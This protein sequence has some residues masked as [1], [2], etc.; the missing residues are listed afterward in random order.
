[1]ALAAGLVLFPVEAGAQAQAGGGRYDLSVRES[2]VGA[3]LEEL[4]A[5]TG[6][7]LVYS[8]E[9]VAGRSTVCRRD[10]ATPEE[11]LRCVVEGAE[12]DFYRLSSGTYVVIEG[13]EALPSYGSLSGEIVDALTGAPVPRARVALADGSLLARANRGGMFVLGRLLPGP[14]TL[15]VSRPGYAPARLAVTIPADGAVRRRVRLDPSVLPLDPIVVEGIQGIGGGTAAEERWSGGG[16]EGAVPVD[17]DVGLQLRRGMGVARRPLF[18]HV[19]IQGSAPGEH[20]VRL[21]GVP[22]FDPV[23]LGRTRSAFSPL[24]LRRITVRKA[25]FGVEQGSFSGGVV[26]VEHAL[27]DRA[28]RGGGTILVDPYSASAGLSLPVRALGG[29]GSLLVSGR[30][31]LWGV[32][33]EGALDEALRRWNEVDP[34]LM[35]RLVGDGGRFTD[36]LDFAPHRHG[37]DLG[38]DDLHAGLRLAFPGFRTLEASFYRGTNRVSTELFAAG[39]DDA[40]GTLDRLLLT[41]DRYGW[42]NL[43]G[44][45]EGHVLV[46]DRASVRVRGWASRHELG[47]VYGMVEGS[48][49]GYQGGTSEVAETEEAL[50]SLLAREAPAEDGNRVEEW[51]LEASADLAAGAGHFLSGGVEAVRVQSG[52]HLLNGFVRPLVSRSDVWRLSGFLKDRWRVTSGL[53][54]EGGFRA[55]SLNGGSTFAEPRAALRLDGDHGALGPWSLRLSGGIYRQFLNTVELTNVG[56]S[57]LVPHVRLWIPADP[58]LDPPR[59]RHLAAE[60]GVE[61]VEGWTLRA[62]AYHKWLD[63]IVALDYGVLLATHGG[64]PEALSQ[65]EFL[66]EAEGVAW[67][68][69]LRAGWERGRARLE[70]GYEWS[71][72][73]RTYPSRFGGERQPAPWNEPHAVSLQARIPVGAGL[74]LETDARSVWG[75]TWGLRRAYFDFLTLHGTEGGP[76]IGLPGEWDLPVLHQID[77]GL[78][79]LG[80]PGGSLVEVQGE[81]RNALGGDQVLDYSLRRG[82]APDGSTHYERVERLLPG[83]ALA[84]TVRVAF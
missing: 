20:V 81:L 47:H 56:P 44:R 38:F 57:A 30:S 70:G 34:V 3:V 59:S 54:L 52:T 72:S 78:S 84:L 66:G 21:D 26:D 36:A 19:S 12:L 39:S 77:V 15:H 49:V 16:V 61:P 67:G 28:G 41:R 1:V 8:S 69:G 5:L 29:E 37:S 74:S 7:S 35:R 45:L 71:L 24:A 43:M 80:R 73:E 18:G 58:T 62:E 76:E 55:T 46:G 53:T 10:G 83:A 65:N 13:P 9:V 32:Y 11:L 25:G 60:L 33:R 75:R 68:V 17:G 27:S 79:W 63:R 40:S 6:I 4:V 22:V 42:S 82:V 31:S 2:A 14:H 23:S 50:R 64:E 51:G 48:E